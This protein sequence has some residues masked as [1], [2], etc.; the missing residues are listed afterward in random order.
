MVGSVENRLSPLDDASVTA[1]PNA[2]SRRKTT[3]KLKRKK[4]QAFRHS[5][6]K[7]RRTTEGDGDGQRA[8]D[9]VSPDAPMGVA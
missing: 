8:T 1:F 3:N 4:P 6:H 9:N 5:L 7:A 2:G